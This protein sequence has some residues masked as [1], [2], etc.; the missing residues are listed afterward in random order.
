MS[1]PAARLAVVL[2]LGATPACGVRGL[3]PTHVIL[4][5][6]RC[7]DGLP[8]RLEVDLACPP[9]GI[10]GYSCHPSRWDDPKGV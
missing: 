5:V 3:L 1:R 7:P 4:V 9:N 2:A 10:C 8:P 6:P